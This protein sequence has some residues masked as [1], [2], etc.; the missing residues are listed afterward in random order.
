MKVV[1]DLIAKHN[2]KVGK[3]APIP[4]NIPAYRAPDIRR[5]AIP[6]QPA[7][8]L[9]RAQY[10]TIIDD[11]PDAQLAIDARFELGDILAQREEYDAAIPLLAEAID[12]EPPADMVDRVRLRRGGCFLAKG[13]AKNAS[14]QF[15]A[16]LQNP[17]SYVAA[18]S[19]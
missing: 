3:D 17:K 7:E 16:I 8:Q 4:A 15:N 13:D 19:E 2:Q 18:R 14:V 10:Q 5:Q 12:M 9:V 1:R 6:V 11:A